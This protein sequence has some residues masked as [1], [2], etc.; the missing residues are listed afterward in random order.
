MV[1]LNLNNANTNIVDS[2]WCSEVRSYLNS[3]AI[4]FDIAVIVN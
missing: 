4:A 1:L 2:F 3:L